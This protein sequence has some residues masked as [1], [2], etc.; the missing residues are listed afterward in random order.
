MKALLCLAVASVSPTACTSLKTIVGINAGGQSVQTSDGTIFER[1]RYFY[2]YL[3]YTFYDGKDDQV[4]LAETE[5]VASSAALYQTERSSTAIFYA[6]P[7]PYNAA[8]RGGSTFVL[9]LKFVNM[10]PELPETFANI[11]VNNI[12]VRPCRF[13]SLIHCVALPNAA[14]VHAMPGALCL[15][16]FRLP[17]PLRLRSSSSRN[18]SVARSK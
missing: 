4:E 17:P 1:D 13:P 14:L 16:R 2:P 10:H 15:P 5:G 11:Y 8:D 6:I 3:E 12:M 18:T 9:T 7:V